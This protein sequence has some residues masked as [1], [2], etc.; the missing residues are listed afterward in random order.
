[1]A[2]KPR[3][4]FEDALYYVITRGEPEATVMSVMAKEYE[5]KEQEIAEYLGRET[6]RSSHDT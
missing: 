3:I 2:R 1:M 5:Y 6:H 4:E